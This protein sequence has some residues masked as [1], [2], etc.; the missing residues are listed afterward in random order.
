MINFTLY[1]R[2][3]KK[4]I[5][6]LF[7]FAAIL[8]LYISVIIRM[9]NPEMLETLDRF[10]EVMP[11]IMSAVGMSTGATSLVGFMISYLYGFI[12]LIFPMIFCILRGNSL[13]SGYVDRGSMVILLAAPVKRST[14]ARTQI[15]VL[16]SGIFL[17][18]MYATILEITVASLSFPGELELSGLLLLNAGLLCLHI[19]IGSICFL[20]SCI[21]SDTKY[22]I[23]FG[24]GIPALMYLLQM[25]A[26]TGEQAETAK[27]FTLFTLFTPDQLASG[28]FCAILKSVVLLTGAVILYAAGILIFR[29]KDLCI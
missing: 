8:T 6:L 12:L 27:Y 4:S 28:E 16:L 22:S 2:E 5:K 19:C 9:Y 11:E 15:S 3:L 20:F 1:K 26:N 21:F 29:K 24:A 17:L 23:G 18:L 7:I 14:I 13:I 25:L 10:V